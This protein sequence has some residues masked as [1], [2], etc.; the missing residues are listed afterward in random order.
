MTHLA[1]I[2]GRELKK[3]GKTQSL[4]SIN[5]S[6]DTVIFTPNLEVQDYYEKINTLL[7]KV[8]ASEPTVLFHN[9]D[10]F[11]QLNHLLAYQKYMVK[12]S[13][14]TQSDRPS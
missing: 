5:S 8:K 14:Y 2:C 13:E 9:E 7:S 1:L 10:S 12:T 4:Q 11:Q 3:I 6:T